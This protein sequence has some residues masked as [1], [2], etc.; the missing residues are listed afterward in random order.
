V[1]SR[2]DAFTEIPT[3][4]P[5]AAIVHTEQKCKAR[6]RAGVVSPRHLTYFSKTEIA[7]AAVSVC[8]RK[9]YSPNLTRCVY[10]PSGPLI[11]SLVSV[12]VCCCGTCAVNDISYG[13]I[14]ASDILSTWT[15]C[16]SRD[17]PRQVI[18]RF[19]EKRRFAG[20]RYGYRTGS[21]YILCI[22]LLEI[23]V[24]Q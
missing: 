14:L 15:N 19:S 4:P 21:Q 13:L 23:R 20:N 8:P 7:A 17:Q 18:I 6:Q 1:R 11:S 22:L 5:R 16:F 9:N 10:P 2:Q 12:K 3:T 24:Q